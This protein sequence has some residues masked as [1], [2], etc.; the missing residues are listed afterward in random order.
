[1]KR[2]KGFSM[3]PLFLGNS[4]WQLIVI[5]DTIT[6]G[7]L[8]TLLGMSLACWTIFFYKFMLFRLKKR[9]LYEIL[10]MLKGVRS[11][12][13][14]VALSSKRVATLPGYFLSHQLAFIK[15]LLQ[16]Q[17]HEQKVLSERDWEQVNQGAEQTFDEIMYQEESYLPLLFATASVATLIGL[18]GTVWGLIHSFIR[19][20]EKQ[21][22]DIAAVAPGIAEALITTLAGLIVAIPAYLMYHYL[23]VQVRHIEH[24]LGRFVDTFMLIAKQLF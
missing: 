24:S 19:I 9:Q 14:L 3:A 22:A 8:F 17:T 10:L 18:F 2:K 13:D 15:E 5:S 20:G 21:S 1:L 12:V 23:M 6:K 11:V 16:R 4:L 7:I